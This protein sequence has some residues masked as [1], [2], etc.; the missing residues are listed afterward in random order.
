MNFS[1]FW[2]K[3]T[4]PQETPV[5]Q[6]AIQPM[7]PVNDTQSD[8]QVPQNPMEDPNV[9]VTEPVMDD[10]NPLADDPRYQHMFDQDKKVDVDINQPTEPTIEPDSVD[11]NEAIIKQLQDQN[12]KMMQMMQTLTNNNKQPDQPV[13]PEKPKD[14]FDSDVFKTMTEAM[15]MDD[16]DAQLFKVFMQKF[17]DQQSEAT[18]SRAMEQTP[19]LVNTTV[20]KQFQ[21]QTMAQDFYKSHPVLDTVKPY[22]K[23]V[24]N[25]VAAQNPGMPLQDVLNQ[26]A[27]TV[28]S[29]LNINPQQVKQQPTAP[30]ETKQKPAFAT[31]QGA[32]RAP[33]RKTNMQIELDAMMADF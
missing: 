3:M 20:N 21:R 2:D 9:Q 6:P 23:Q 11:P 27:K 10:T 32:R 33:A 31:T 22:V 15:N 30:V 12:D 17:A 1:T 26:T 4:N 5:Q 18:L 24:A 29:T 8:A 13:E 14:V 28:Y 25:A 7:E 19:E 16:S